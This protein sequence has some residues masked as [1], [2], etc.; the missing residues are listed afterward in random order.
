MS[1]CPEYS[2][3]DCQYVYEERLICDVTRA[4]GVLTYLDPDVERDYFR[5]EYC[6]KEGRAFV[7]RNRL[8][9]VSSRCY[10]LYRGD[11]VYSVMP[12]QVPTKNAHCRTMTVGNVTYP[13]HEYFLDRETYVSLGIG[14]S[15]RREG[16]RQLAV[17]YYNTPQQVAHMH[18]FV[19]YDC[20][21]SD[22]QRAI[23]CFLKQQ[24]RFPI[25]ECFYYS[26]SVELRS[27]SKAWS[28]ISYVTD[29]GLRQI[30]VLSCGAWDACS[31][32]SANALSL[33][34]HIIIP[35]KQVCLRMENVYYEPSFSINVMDWIGAVAH[36]H[37]DYY[38][39]HSLH[40][41]QDSGWS[42]M[43]IIPPLRSLGYVYTKYQAKKHLG[44]QRRPG[45]V[46]S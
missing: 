30:V 1:E 45:V 23:Q 38:E 29:E 13:Y 5:L 10:V 15:R 24:T 22:M 12:L 31:Y 43:N 32:E 39:I 35:D 41:Y 7:F 9:P 25:R 42:S 17:L 2:Y 26:H 33:M 3:Y 16:R 36:E 20:R 21:K 8:A 34:Y 40:R 37:L 18:H 27:V 4:G 6:D 11:D 14:H 46:S 44:F 19:D 28:H